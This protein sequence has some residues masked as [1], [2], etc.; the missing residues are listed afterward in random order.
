L[1]RLPQPLSIDDCRLSIANS[2]K[3]RARQSAIDNRK[4]EIL[5]VSTREAVDEYRKHDERNQDV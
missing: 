4:S 1:I 3:G 2:K 5:Q